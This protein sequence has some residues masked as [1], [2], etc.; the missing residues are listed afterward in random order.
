MISKSAV[1]TPGVATPPRAPNGQAG[2][3]PAYDGGR[4]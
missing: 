1:A 3:T 4:G 2:L